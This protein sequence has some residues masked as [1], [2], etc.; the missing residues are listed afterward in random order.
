[1]SIRD[2]WETPTALFDVLNR[3][4]N[5][6]ID[7][8]ATEQNAKCPLFLDYALVEPWR[9]SEWDDHR[10]S[11]AWCNPPYSQIGTFVDRAINQLEAGCESVLLLPNDSS[12]KWFSKCVGHCQEIRF[13]TGGRVQFNPPAGV[14]PSSNTGS[15]ILAIFKRRPWTQHRAVLTAWNWKDEISPYDTESAV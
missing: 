11:M 15:S 5:F 8:A 12:T 4:F 6:T 3:E 10:P 13:L 14:K 9:S 1:M 2:N 7:V